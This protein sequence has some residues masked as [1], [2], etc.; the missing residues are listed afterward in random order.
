MR[1]C[2]RPSGRWFPGRRRDFALGAA[3]QP[4]AEQDADWQI[5]EFGSV[6]QTQPMSDRVRPAGETAC[7]H[8][9]GFHPHQADPRAE[10]DHDTR[11]GR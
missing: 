2:V 5:E 11:A 10:L 6:R 1:S 9:V 4:L 8:H 3:F 7:P